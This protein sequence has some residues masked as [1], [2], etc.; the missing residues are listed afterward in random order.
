MPTPVFQ[1]AFGEKQQ[2]EDGNGNPRVG[3]KLF[4]YIA[5]TLTKATT[6]QK[7]DGIAANTNPIILDGDGALP[8]GLYVKSGLYDIALAPPTDTDPPSSPYWTRPDLTPFNDTSLTLDQWVVANGTPTWTGTTT[9][10]LSGDQT[11]D[12]QVGRRVRIVDSGG[13]KYG[14]IVSAVFAA[15]TTVT[16]VLDSGVLATPISSVQYGLLT[17]TNPSIPALTSQ[18]WIITTGGANRVRTTAPAIA[19]NSQTTNYQLKESDY[20][21]AV[22]CSGTFT[23]DT[24]AA[25]TLGDGWW[26]WV[27]NTGTGII[28][29]DP[30]GSETIAVPGGPQTPGTSITLPYSGSV[31]GPYNVSG[32]LLYCTGTGFRVLATNEVHGAQVFTGSGT[33]TCPAGVNT[34]WLDGAAQGGGGGAISAVAGASAGGGGAGQALVFERY[35]V[36]PGTAYTVTLANSGGTGGSAGNNPG[37]AGSNA[38]FGA[39]VTLT[40]GSG[41]S[42][43]AGGTPIGGGAAGGAGGGP[44]GAGFNISGSAASGGEGGSGFWGQGGPR[45]GSTSGGVNATGFGAGGS[46]ACTGG[47]AQPGGNGSPGFFRVHW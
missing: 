41:G 16:V 47:T 9:F 36:V 39:L 26:C 34:I 8:Y 28:T 42:G 6:Y 14:N 38:V 24:I 46:G 13:T 12:A 19:T 35:A 25:A 43:S 30:N 2:F 22:S 23:L 15:N 37:T 5:G 17:A 20:G 27:V 21:K 44:G 11:T 7:T 18:R 1:L 10:T 31:E 33:W 29:I 4:V 40:G 32:V 3:A 45:T